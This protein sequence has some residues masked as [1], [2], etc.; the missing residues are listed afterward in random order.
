MKNRTK[1]WMSLTLMCGLLPFSF[2]FHKGST[3]W[4][5]QQ[6]QPAA[7]IL[8]IAALIFAFLWIRS[9]LQEKSEK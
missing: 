1:L 8:G 6:T 3:E 4:I 5:W 2:T 9:G 7:W